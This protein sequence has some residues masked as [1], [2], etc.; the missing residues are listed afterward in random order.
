MNRHVATTP[1]IKKKNSMFTFEIP[2]VPF[3]LP[4]HSFYLLKSAYPE[5]TPLPSFAL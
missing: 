5:I 2:G 4:S 3:T 1:Q